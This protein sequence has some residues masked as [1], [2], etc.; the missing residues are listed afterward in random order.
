LL[1]EIEELY[2]QSRDISY[3]LSEA[4]QGGFDERIKT[5]LA[6]FKGPGIHMALAGNTVELWSKV[7][8]GTRRELMYILQ[9]LMVNMRKHS[10]ATTVGLH[11]KI[12]GDGLEVRYADNGI[13]F[14]V[15]V[16]FGNGLR[17]TEN[18][19]KR[20]SGSFTFDTES[21]KGV[22]VR[23]SFPNP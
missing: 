12:N 19:I 13:G 16:T 7:G 18:R 5:L 14:P 22:R 2:E 9:E 23:L 11:F 15:N 21:K 4:G 20:M 3:E 8:T 1:D 17:N 10:R 6:D